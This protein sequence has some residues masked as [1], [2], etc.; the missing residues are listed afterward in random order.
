MAVQGLVEV[1]NRL[2]GSKMHDGLYNVAW[3]CL[4]DANS[5]EQDERVLEAL[6]VGQVC[7]TNKQL[8]L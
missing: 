2:E 3:Q 4:L 6:K 8:D 5:Y 7:H 1:C